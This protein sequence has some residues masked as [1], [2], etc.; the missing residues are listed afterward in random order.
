MK[1]S[2]DEK[3]ENL[4][5]Q[6]PEA[7]KSKE[8][9]ESGKFGPEMRIIP[10]IDKNLLQGTVTLTKCYV[11]AVQNRKIT[12]ELLSFPT[13]TKE[14]S[15]MV[16]PENL[17]NSR[18]LPE[19]PSELHHLR[20]VDNKSSRILL[21]PEEKA[22]DDPELW[23]KLKNLGVQK[24]H[25]E[26]IDI[27][28]VRPLTRLQFD[29]AK[30][31]W[32]TSYPRN[33]ELEAT[34]NGALFSDQEKGQIRKWSDR[35]EQKGCIIV[36]NDTAIASSSSQPDVILGHS[37]IETVQELAKMERE[38]GSYLATDCDVFVDKEPCGMC[39]MALVH[40]RAKRVF[41]NKP[42]K[43]GV[44]KEGPWQLHLEPSLNHHYAVFHLD[45]TENG[46]FEEKFVCC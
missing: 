20:R 45:K 5:D 27:P 26:L 34:I 40:A 31:K 42:S 14:L 36:Q 21:H 33:P 19:I 3:F 6:E 30:E 39:A 46:N 7:K 16:P 12:G 1:R 9:G 15:P 18:I 25:V 35:V 38:D 2:V 43:N 44:L 32:A 37:A 23:S 10:I 29:W 17:E 8:N 11:I 28:A 4:D 24:E 13:K 41:F 22:K